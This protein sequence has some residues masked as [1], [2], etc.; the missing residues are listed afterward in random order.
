MIR[1]DV[2]AQ[3]AA[4]QA[5]STKGAD[6]ADGQAAEAVA[7]P[8]PEANRLGAAP[9]LPRAPWLVRNSRK[10]TIA[11]VLAIFAASPFAYLYLQRNFGPDP[12]R[13]IKLDG[14]KIDPFT[15]LPEVTKPAAI[16]PPDANPSLTR[17]SAAA[18]PV[19]PAPKTRPPERFASPAQSAAT[20]PAAP[21]LG[22][23]H[24]RPGAATPVKP[25]AAPPVAATSGARGKSAR[26]REDIREE[27]TVS[28][29]CTEAVA[30]LGFCNPNATEKAK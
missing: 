12:L 20:A 10:A 26:P 4:N 7:A 30:A 17:P 16:R 2:R 18:A 19:E 21:S 23:T 6:G 28:G 22:V 13:G 9:G 5:G 3:V 11:L 8:P 15:G 27:Q 25:E 14:V 29:G 24:T 1:S